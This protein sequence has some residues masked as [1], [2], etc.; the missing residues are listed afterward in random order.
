MAQLRKPE[1]FSDNYGALFNDLLIL[2]SIVGNVPKA[3][4]DELSRELNT[5]DLSL[6]EKQY[7]SSFNKLFKQADRPTIISLEGII[8]LL[9]KVEQKDVLLQDFLICSGY[10]NKPSVATN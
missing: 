5:L 8:R 6:R 9:E 1:F 7:A 2:K 3:F 10:S 4:H